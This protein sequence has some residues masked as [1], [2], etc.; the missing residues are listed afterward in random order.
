MI[1][2]LLK[3]LIFG[4]LVAL[5]PILFNLLFALTVG[6]EVTAGRLIGRGELLLI[7]VGLCSTALGDLVLAELSVRSRFWRG[8]RLILT[9]TCV[10]V[11]AA[12]SFYFALVSD[13]YARQIAVSDDAVVIISSALYLTAVVCSGGSVWLSER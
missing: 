7:A 3:W 4:V 12:S 1:N 10:V 8:V 6:A 13:R 11:I 9:G 5:L 2:K